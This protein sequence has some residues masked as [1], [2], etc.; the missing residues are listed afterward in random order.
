MRSEHGPGRDLVFQ[1]RTFM[2]VGLQVT[3]AQQPYEPHREQN[4]RQIEDQQAAI[5]KEAPVF[6][7]GTSLRGTMPESVKRTPT[8]FSLALE[9]MTRRSLVATSSG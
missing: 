7:S 9:D 3:L 4:Q 6:F 5:H 8:V 1:N 2:R